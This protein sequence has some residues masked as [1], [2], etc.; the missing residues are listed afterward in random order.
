M[1]VACHAGDTEVRRER[2]A[3]GDYIGAFVARPTLYGSSRDRSTAEKES[4]EDVYPKAGPF[5]HEKPWWPPGVFA[6]LDFYDAGQYTPDVMDIETR[7][8]RWGFIRFAW[9]D[10]AR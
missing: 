7:S 2:R 6:S 9:I 10:L 1:D 5:H 4:R 3:A 8:R